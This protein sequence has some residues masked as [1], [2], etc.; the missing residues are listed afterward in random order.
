MNKVRWA[1][2]NWKLVC[3]AVVAASVGLAYLGMRYDFDNLVAYSTL[4]AIVFGLP[5]VPKNAWRQAANMSRRKMATIGNS[6][7]LT[8]S[9]KYE[10]RALLYNG[11]GGR[12]TYC[13]RAIPIDLMQ[14]EH[15]NPQARKGSAEL[16]NLHL[17]CSTCNNH[18]HKRTHEEYL[19]HIRVHGTAPE[20]RKRDILKYS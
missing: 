7:A 16:R 15:K 11:Q 14:V 2:R 20:L 12:C 18:K 5:L 19:R 1:R 3:G 8:Q 10:T 4:A 17:T 9:A 13:R 6:S